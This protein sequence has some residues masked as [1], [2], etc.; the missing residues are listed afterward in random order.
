MTEN[1]AAQK[2][3]E[4]LTSLETVKKYAS[5]REKFL[6]LLF[7]A[8]IAILAIALTKFSINYYDYLTVTPY[9]GSIPG[10]G[11]IGFMGSFYFLIAPVLVIIAAFS[12]IGY[13]TINKALKGASTPYFDN[14]REDGILG[15]L[16]IFNDIDRESILLDISGAKQGYI[17]LSA[18]ITI[19]Y[20]VM[21]FVILEIAF[22]IGSIITGFL[23][24]M[25]AVIASSLAIILI[26]RRHQYAM[27]YKKIWYL[28]SLL[29]ELRWLYTEFKG[30][31]LQ[32]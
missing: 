11:T 12:F 24:P 3:S 2:V 32:A 7:M 26:V 9:L 18:L 20:W 19:F 15:I 31:E 25:W 4:L 10:P 16:K 30:S 14:L 5:V 22:G 1:D 6:P 29:W 17:L 13:L 28:D 21:L 27:D 23:V 8:L